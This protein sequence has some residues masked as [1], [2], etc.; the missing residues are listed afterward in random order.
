MYIKNNQRHFSSIWRDKNISIA[1]KVK[2]MRTLILSTFLSA[3]ESWT[4]TA[5]IER[6]I[7]ALQMRCYRRLLNI[8]YKDHV[9][10]EEVHNRIQNAIRVHDDLTEIKMVWP[11]LKILWHGENN[12]AGDSERS[13]KERTTEEEMG[14]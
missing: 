8:S 3:C 14:R 13:K 4:V 2:L 10:N 12:S 9:T 6:R 1:S 5:D 11:Y 7:Q